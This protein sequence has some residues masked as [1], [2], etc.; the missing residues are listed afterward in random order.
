MTITL[1]DE[2]EGE[3]DDEH[4]LSVADRTFSL[5]APHDSLTRFR[6]T[7]I[8][9]LDHTPRPIFPV[10]MVGNSFLELLFD[11]FTD[12]GVSKCDRRWMYAWTDSNDDVK[13]D[14]SV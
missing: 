13:F 6:H 11:C 5:S 8:P 1:D 10:V 9:D 7:S 2:R 3:F 12:S 14:D 4:I